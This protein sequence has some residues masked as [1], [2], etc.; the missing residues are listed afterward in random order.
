[1]LIRGYPQCF[2]VRQQ[3]PPVYL[4]SSSNGIVTQATTLPAGVFGYIGTLFGP[5]WYPFLSVLFDPFSHFGNLV[6]N[7][8]V[9]GY[10]S[11]IVCLNEAPYFCRL[12][13]VP[14]V[15]P[16]LANSLSERRRV[17][18]GP[19][20]ERSRVSQLSDLRVAERSCPDREALPADPSRSLF[21]F[22]W[23]YQFFILSPAQNLKTIAVAMEIN[24]VS[25]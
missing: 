6:S 13:I 10:Q 1:M 7:L 17:R 9:E 16:Q 22:S 12:K 11:Q 14:K 23:S 19:C 18:R 24:G 4:C 25:L 21:V 20:R 8:L 15:Q 3:N 5:L 2:I